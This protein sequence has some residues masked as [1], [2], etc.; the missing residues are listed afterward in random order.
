M[1]LKSQFKLQCDVVDADRQVTFNE[2]FEMATQ[3]NIPFVETSA[4]TGEN[5]GVT[6]SVLS[7]L[8]V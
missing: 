2:G 5:V 1:K 6:N 8:I 3:Y 7:T 4:K